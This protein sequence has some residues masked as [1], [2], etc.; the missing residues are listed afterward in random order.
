[1]L[2][3]IALL[4]LC[5]KYS[6]V[7]SIAQVKSSVA[8]AHMRSASALRSV[9]SLCSVVLLQL[10]K[11]NSVLHI[12]ACCVK[13]IVVCFCSAVVLRLLRVSVK[14]LCK[15]VFTTLLFVLLY[16]YFVACS[17]KHCK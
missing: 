17:A 3:C 15:H 10:H 7:N 1:M 6:N 9:V 12:C 2:L 14:Q 11:R 16:A 8:L 5:S 4:A 13:L